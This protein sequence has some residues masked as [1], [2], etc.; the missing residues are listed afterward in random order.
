MYLGCTSRN[1]TRF[2]QGR[3]RQIPYVSDRKRRW[4]I[5]VKYQNLLC[6]KGPCVC[7]LSRFSCV[8]LF[9]ARQAPLSMRFSRQEYWSG[10][11]CLPPRIFLTQGLNLCL[12]HC[13]HY[14]WPTR[15]ARYKGLSSRISLCQSLI[16]PWWGKGIPPTP[17]A[18]LS[19]LKEK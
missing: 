13:R 7:V 4:I 2:P 16:P 14:R 3:S 1:P 15:K 19:Y 5:S 18:F 9:G 12:L 6:Y 10:L 11:P 17:L 8:Q